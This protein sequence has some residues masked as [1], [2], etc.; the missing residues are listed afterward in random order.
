[1]LLLNTAITNL[2]FCFNSED[3]YFSDGLSDLQ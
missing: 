2:D 3:Y 1:L